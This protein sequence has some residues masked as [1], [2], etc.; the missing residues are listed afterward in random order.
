[1]R[2]DT[3]AGILFALA[4]LGML[5]AMGTI[6]V[7]AD[8]YS[9]DYK[10]GYKAALDGPGHIMEV[11]GMLNTYLLMIENFNIDANNIYINA[12]IKGAMS[13]LIPTYN[14]CSAKY[15]IATR[16]ANAEIK[17]VLDSDAGDYLF[18]RRGYY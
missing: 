2:K 8:E 12:F 1:M 16:I 14:D 15:N 11:R 7:S 18:E 5:T 10:E 9:Y 4:C 13:K 3:I 6:L 17:D